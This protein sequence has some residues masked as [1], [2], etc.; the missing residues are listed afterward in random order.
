MESVESGQKGRIHAFDVIRGFSVISMVLFHF[1]YDLKFIAGLRLGFF[2]SPFI[3]VWRAIISWTFVFIAGCMFSYSRNNFKRSLKYLAVALLI[4]VITTLARVDIPINF[5][6]IFCM[7]ACTL[8]CF[9]LDRVGVHV[10][11]N[12]ISII[13]AICFLLCLHVPSGYFGNFGLALRLPHQL[14]DCGWLSWA[15]FP[16]PTFSSGD[17]Y[18]LIPFVFLYLSGAAFSACHHDAGYAT[19]FEK[20]HCSPLEFVGR[21][22]LAIYIFHQPVLLLLTMLFIQ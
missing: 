18:P 12:L 3:D 15:G 5:G 8:T 2:A 16:S 7:G 19:W 17:Y 10:K 14:Y 21:H 11:G 22:A 9:V 13:M 4:F 1:C 20:L 6:I